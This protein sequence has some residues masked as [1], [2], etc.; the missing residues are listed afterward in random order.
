MQ[1][2]SSG[3]YCGWW[4]TMVGLLDALLYVII[5]AHLLRSLLLALLWWMVLQWKN[6]ASPVDNRNKHLASPVGNKTKDGASSAVNRKRKENRVSSVGNKN[7]NMASH[8]DNLNKK[9]CLHQLAIKQSKIWNHQHRCIVM[10]L[11][12]FVNLTLII[13]RDYRGSKPNSSWQRRKQII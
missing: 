10:I 6:S 11:S 2:F 8:V 7:N 13:I 1:T 5:K 4:W 12:I 9:V 3:V